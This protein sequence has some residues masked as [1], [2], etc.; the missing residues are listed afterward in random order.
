M[1]SSLRS[2]RVLSYRVA[3]SRHKGAVQHAY[4]LYSWL[5]YHVWPLAMH[6]RHHQACAHC[7]RLAGNSAAP[8]A[9][10]LC[11]KGKGSNSS[12]SRTY[13]DSAAALETADNV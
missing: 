12:K 4:D 2:G 11:C 6:V 13:R 7:C 3:E 8:S 5:L 9:A 1:F 10:S